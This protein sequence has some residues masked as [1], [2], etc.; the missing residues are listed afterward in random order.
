MWWALREEAVDR[1][2]VWRIGTDNALPFHGL[3][4]GPDGK[5]RPHGIVAEL[6][7]QAAERRGIRL[8]WVVTRP[9]QL[10]SGGVDIW[11]LNA[12][13]G[14]PAQLRISRPIL[15][16]VFTG[17]VR[18]DEA[19][20]AERA[21][22]TVLVRGSWANQLASLLFP[23]AKAR[24][25]PS[26]KEALEA[27]CRGEGELLL[28]EARLLQSMLLE[29]PAACD[30]VGLGVRGLEVEPI[31]MGI[32]HR[33][34]AAE[35][36]AEI[37]DEIDRMIEEGQARS[38]LTRWAFFASEEVE[39]LYTEASAREANRSVKQLAGMLFALLVGITVLYRE[40]SLARETARAADLAKTQFLANMSHEIRTPLNGVI[41]LADVLEKTPLDR[42]QRRLL[43]MM[44]SSGRN[45]LAIVNDVLDLARVARGEW[46]LELASV[47]LALLLE[48]AAQPY[49][50]QAGQKGLQFRVEGLNALP[51]A[52]SCDPV[53]VRQMVTNLLGNALKFTEH[54]EVWKKVSGESEGDRWLVSVEVGDTGI[55]MS[56]ATQAKLF[57]KF[58]QADSSIS[59]RFG[60]TGLGLSIVRELAMAMGGDV[61]VKS[62]LGAGSVFTLRIP[63]RVLDT[64][65]ARLP[66]EA[67]GS[68]TGG[69]EKLRV[70]VVEDNL[71][72]QVVAQGILEHAGHSVTTVDNGQVAVARVAEEEFDV[73][74]IDCQMP[75]MVGYQATME[76][77]RWEGGRG[78]VPILAL[79]ASAMQGERE[80]CLACGMDGILTKPIRPEDLLAAV[81]AN[82]KTRVLDLSR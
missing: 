47:D 29:R 73:V 77:R 19:D 2:R 38:I 10:Q 57:E 13:R 71:V 7:E 76:I 35:V 23:K 39:L 81:E 5:A 8:E 25:L 65:L 79:T 33:V 9:D 16:N 11:T 75:V 55:G 48:D 46:T 3:R 62:E 72:N 49:R 17:L 51:P 18:K 30:G 53:R 78:R 66:E 52:V 14:F 37:R 36:V 58:Y 26:R 31:Q 41:G 54:G 64:E 69:R 24:S 74:L 6:V 82:A 27:L 42:E 67:S 32:G 43:G 68:V 21:P 50:V 15:R 40:A 80:R 1:S 56:A 44:R 60:G 20:A 34:E 12:I 22:R 63:L 70:L 45:L 4:T 59:R 28:M 61:S